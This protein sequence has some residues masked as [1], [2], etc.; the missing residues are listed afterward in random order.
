MESLH[1]SFDRE[2]HLVPIDLTLGTKYSFLASPDLHIEEFRKKYL[3]MVSCR[4]YPGPLN[5][6]L[7][8]LVL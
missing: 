4:K 6:M 3:F 8:V 2:S 1:R 5:I 7:L